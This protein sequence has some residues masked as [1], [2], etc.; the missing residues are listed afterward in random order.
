[1]GKAPGRIVAETPRS[2]GR[3]KEGVT[4]S[5]LILN[6]LSDSYLII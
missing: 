4:R 2:L 3:S 1:M 5:L 6:H